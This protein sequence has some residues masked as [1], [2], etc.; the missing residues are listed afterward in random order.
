[1][2][3]QEKWYSCGPGSIVNALRAQGV[4]VDERR[5][6]PMANCE[7]DCGTDEDGVIAAIRALG[8]SA[9][10][11][12]DKSRNNAWRWLRGALSQGNAVI[13]SV[14][15]WRHWVTCV[16]LL[17]DRVIVI[18]PEQ[19]KKNMKENGVH[20]L[21]KDTFMAQ[22]RSSWKASD[23]IYYGICVSKAKRQ[24]CSVG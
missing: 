8:H 23:N 3:Y 9:S 2:R 16:G 11:F 13:I 6:R 20:I 14:Y 5:I 17:G 22:W 18:D 1:M 24:S 15:F 10:T 4:R 7:Q 12:Q 19:T 21:S